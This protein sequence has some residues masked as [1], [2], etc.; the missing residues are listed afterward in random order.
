MDYFDACCKNNSSLS[1]NYDFQ[2][3]GQDDESDFSL[4]KFSFLTVGRGGGHTN[5]KYK[6]VILNVHKFLC[7]K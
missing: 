1:N 3:K 2:K 6:P 4:V 7:L 5:G